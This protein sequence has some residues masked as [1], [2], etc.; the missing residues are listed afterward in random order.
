MSGW[1]SIE[2]ALV[3]RMVMALLMII[4]LGLQDSTAHRAAQAGCPSTW[5]ITGHL[6]TVEG[7]PK[8]YC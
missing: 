7:G 3:L 8:M 1:T 4:M 2:N 5:L 6:G